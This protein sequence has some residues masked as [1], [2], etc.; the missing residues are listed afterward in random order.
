[1]VAEALWGL[2]TRGL[3]S[4][5][6]SVL[7][8]SSPCFLTFSPFAHPGGPSCVVVV[9]CIFSFLASQDDPPS[10]LPPCLSHHRRIVR[11]V[12]PLLFTRTHHIPPHPIPFATHPTVRPIWISDDEHR[13][14][15]DFPLYTSG[16]EKRSKVGI[17]LHNVLL[18]QERERGKPLSF[19]SPSSA[20]H[21]TFPQRTIFCACARAALRC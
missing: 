15:P 4:G 5:F 2:L 3:R 18:S 19:F 11:L 1:M 12:S 7:L 6:R 14:F 20:H 8:L 13:H 16:L 21:S 9:F 17:Y 10:P